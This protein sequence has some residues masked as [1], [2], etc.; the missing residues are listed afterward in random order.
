MARTRSDFSDSADLLCLVAA[1]VI[2]ASAST[3]SAAMHVEALRGAP[4][5]DDVP[6][7][8]AGPEVGE[9]AKTETLV[10][11]AIDGGVQKLTSPPAI[12]ALELLDLTDETR[13]RVDDLL[14]ERAALMDTL[15]LSNIELLSQ[16]E[17]V[18]A[19]GTPSEKFNIMRE[20]LQA[21]GPVR[22][23]GK[24]AT[25]LAEALPREQRSVYRLQIREY[26]RS[27]Y[28]LALA[29]G[30]VDNKLGYRMTRHWEDLGWEIERA[31]ERVF[32]DTEDGD[33]WIQR[34]TERLGL[35]PD[36]VGEIRALGERFYIESRGRPSKS[37][38]MAFVAKLRTVMTIEQKWKFTGM[39]LR[40][41]LDPENSDRDEE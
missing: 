25:R 35:T 2:A 21:L 40:G 8:L 3:A 32:D 17:T 36:Q 20:G 37:E 9:P 19:V 11:Q 38:E 29:G 39:M 23:W 13:E 41:E 34:L 15:V 5:P 1:A 28:E 22:A 4:E 6:N 33:A 7:L 24:L 26:D 18:M 10:T 27:R 12:A 30:E 14:A 16:V 31:A